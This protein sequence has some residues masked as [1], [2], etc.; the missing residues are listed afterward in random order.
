LSSQD[1]P[2]AAAPAPAE[3]RA[4]L[5]AV[6]AGL[7]ALVL[8]NGAALWAFHNDGGNAVA[9]VGAISSPIVAMVS[10]YFGIK[11]GTQTGAASAAAADQARTQA[12]NQVKSMLGQLDPAK[13]APIMRSLGIPVA[14]DL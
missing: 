13:A 2:V 5:Y 6:W 10:A 7:A 14:P 11:V 3:P 4:G 12:D 9:A 8:L 1:Q